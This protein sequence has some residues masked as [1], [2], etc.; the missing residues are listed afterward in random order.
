MKAFLTAEKH[1][2]RARLWGN[3]KGTLLLNLFTVRQGMGRAKAVQI[4]RSQIIEVFTVIST[5]K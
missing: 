1:E 5:Y 3:T 2:Q 4:G